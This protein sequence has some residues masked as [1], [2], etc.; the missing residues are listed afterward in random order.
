MRKSFARNL[1][2]HR[3]QRA[4]S[5]KGVLIGRGSSEAISLDSTHYYPQPRATI[6]KRDE[7]LPLLYYL[8]LRAGS[9][10]YPGSSRP[11]RKNS[12][13]SRSLALNAPRRLTCPA[14]RLQPLP[15]K[16]D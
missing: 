1:G 13:D 6:S 16:I 8:L 12:T 7:R 11:R 10:A 2:T 3:F 14:M 9:D 4:V 15:W 5:A